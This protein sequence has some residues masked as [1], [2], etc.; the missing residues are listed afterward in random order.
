MPKNERSCQPP[1]TTPLSQSFQSINGVNNMLRKRRDEIIK[2]LDKSYLE[3]F[4]IR[5]VKNSDE[6]IPQKEETTVKK[7]NGEIN[8]GKK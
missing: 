5:F 2:K 7:N 1:R 3:Q 6:I 8:N 4:K